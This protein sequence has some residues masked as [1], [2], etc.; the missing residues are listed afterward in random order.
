MPVA[1][2]EKVAVAGAVTVWLA[3]WVVMD[4][5]V[6]AAFTVRVALLEVALPALLVTTQ[7]KVAPLSAV[8]VA[9]VV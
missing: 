7:R 2:T 5:A 3:G 8:L 9:G 1:V 6:G 4:G